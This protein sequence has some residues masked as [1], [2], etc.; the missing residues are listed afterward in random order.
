MY[1][2]YLSL[3]FSNEMDLTTEMAKLPCSYIY[4]NVIQNFLVV[5][6]SQDSS[7]W[8]GLTHTYICFFVYLFLFLLN[9]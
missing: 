6:L 5:R 3:E 8:L 4:K 9:Y 1:T 7:V 2:S